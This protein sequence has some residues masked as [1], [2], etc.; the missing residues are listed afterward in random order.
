[1]K[2]TCWMGT[3]SVE[4]RAVPDPQSLNHC[5]AIVRTT[6]TAICGSG[7]S[8]EG[9]KLR[10]GRA[11]GVASGD[12]GVVGRDASPLSQPRGEET[13]PGPSRFR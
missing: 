1:M 2:T 12:P 5:D 7:L 4:V 11:E 8:E 9:R 6:S 13:L 10:E 3:G